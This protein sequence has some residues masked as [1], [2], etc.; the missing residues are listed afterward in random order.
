[1]IPANTIPLV[2]QALNSSKNTVV[3][4]KNIQLAVVEVAVEEVKVS[5]WNS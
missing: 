4:S 2:L 5:L 3:I 1:M